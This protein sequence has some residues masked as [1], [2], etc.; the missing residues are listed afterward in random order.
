MAN[1]WMA[2]ESNPHL[3][4]DD[5]V[6]LNFFSK[7]ADNGITCIITSAVYAHYVES[8]YYFLL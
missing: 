2:V 7:Q 3:H 6:H 5:R 8:T 4:T 1:F